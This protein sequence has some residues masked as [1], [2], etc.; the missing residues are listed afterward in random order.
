MLHYFVVRM[1]VRWSTYFFFLLKCS[2]LSIFKQVT[3]LF[4]INSQSISG[5]SKLFSVKSQKVNILGLWSTCLPSNHSTQLLLPHKKR[6]KGACLSKTL[7]TLRCES[8]IIFTGHE[9][10]VFLIF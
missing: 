2:L 3:V 5:A 9:I 8:Y 10:L 1:L 6:N 4:S 7:L